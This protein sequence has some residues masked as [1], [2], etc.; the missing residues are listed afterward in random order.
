MDTQQPPRRLPD[1]KFRVLIIGRANAGKT[2]ILQR[3]CD[4]TQ[5]P[6]IYRRTRS[7]WY[8]DD[9]EQVH[10]LTFVNSATLV[11]PLVKIQL[12][13]STERGEHS[14]EDELV[15]SN[16]DGYIFH[17][18]RGFES[19][20]NNEL[21]IVQKYCVPMDNQRPEL[22]LKHFKDICPDQNVPIIGVFTKYDQFRRN[23][24]MHLQDHQNENLGG[25]PADEADRRFEEDYLRPLGEGA[26]FVRVEKMHKANARCDELVEKTAEALNHDVVTLMLLAVQRSNL[27]LSVKLAVKW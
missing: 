15:F 3:V 6:V 17:D 2:S 14:I 13:P 1:I 5:S 26:R 11:S 21:E 23:I 16:H 22:D 9:K 25:N 18:S 24:K 10:G 20:D 8:S 7:S 12:H 27:E 4:T 19:G